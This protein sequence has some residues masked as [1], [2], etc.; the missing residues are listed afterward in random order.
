[1]TLEIVEPPSA[2]PRGCRRVLDST[3]GT[4]FFG[5]FLAAGLLFTAVLA[6]DAWYDLETWTWTEVPCRILS[7]EVVDTGA[8]DDPYTAVVRFEYVHGGD[9]FVGDR[10]R[11]R[12]V[13]SGSWAELVERV[14]RYPAGSDATCRLDPDEPAAAVLE[15]SVPWML[16]MFPLPLVFVA[17][18]GIGVVAMLRRDRGGQ[19]H[20]SP[21][22]REARRG[23]RAM[24]I[25]IVLGAVF[26]IVGG[27]LFVV[28]GVLPMVRLAD[29]R[30]W[31]EVPCTVVSSTV[32]SHASDDGTTYSIDILYEYESA[33]R[34]WRSNRYDF[35][36]GSSSG[37]DGKKA[38]VDR[39][40]AGSTATCWV[41]PGDP[42]Q[43]VL[44]R[45]L[46][47]RYLIGLFPL[48]FFIPGIGVL[49][50]GVRMWRRA[51][52]TPGLLVGARA[53]VGRESMSTVTTPT[54]TVATDPAGPLDLEPAV[55]PVGKAAGAGCMAVFW[56]GIVGVFVWQAVAG[57]RRGR[58]D[59]FLT[60][61]LVPFVLVGAAFIGSVFYFLLAAANPRPRLR[62]MPGSPRLGDR[63]QVEWSFTG[64]VARIRR[65]EIRL[66]G[67][68]EA[69][70]RRGTDTVTDREEFARLHVAASELGPEIRAGSRE[71]EVPADAMHSLE[72]ASNKIVWT[73]EVSGDI[74]RWPDVSE[75]F[76][77][78]VRPPGP[79]GD[80]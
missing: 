47:V 11:R 42:S 67:R 30:G 68:E 31:Q 54:S 20:P 41:D 14:S 79:G 80:R 34:T 44:E 57:W 69:T 37:Y 10:L 2:S 46:S 26:T 27:A 22:S 4:L 24:W 6:R 40:P 58:P 17:V 21:I 65:L 59:W 18:G 75:T 53:T 32:R 23:R 39:Y 9:A 5:V 71:V 33:G 19:R 13:T 43:A 78:V 38:V 16:L 60:L 76:P 64:R 51:D 56:N 73:L 3:V 29:A 70:Y 48:M 49:W 62:I 77:V 74:S 45:R 12:P 25:P 15:R 8:A 50:F 66:V 35:I 63:L 1:V 36:G 55:G 61:F 7:S 72:A 28:F 52:T